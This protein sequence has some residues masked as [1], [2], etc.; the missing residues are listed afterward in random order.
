MFLPAACVFCQVTPSWDGNKLVRKFEAK[1]SRGKS[2]T[3]TFELLGDEL[4]LV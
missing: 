3:H 1:D 4:V 2:Q